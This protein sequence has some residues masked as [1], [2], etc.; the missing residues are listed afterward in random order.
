MITIIKLL[1]KA[2]IKLAKLIIYVITTSFLI[3]W[4][5]KILGAIESKPDAEIYI[6]DMR[7]FIE[8]TITVII[9]LATWLPAVLKKYTLACVKICITFYEWSLKNKDLIIQF[10]NW[11]AIIG[12]YAVFAAYV[13]KPWI[14]DKIGYFFS[15]KI[16][17]MF[18][19]KIL[20]DFKAYF[21]LPKIEIP[22][23]LK[24]TLLVVLFFTGFYNANLLPEKVHQ[25]TEIFVTFIYLFALYHKVI[26]INIANDIKNFIINVI[27]PMWEMREVI[28]WYIIKN[29]Y[30]H[31]QAILQ[32]I[33]DII[34]KKP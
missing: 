30:E 28:F 26:F 15:E 31:I 6:E 25:I 3:W 33:Q 14:F 20:E 18:K 27:I 29:M 22:V 16:R 10:S 21:K 5:I 4:A 17:K 34:S 1:I 11:G 9:Y 24:K 13:Y 23:L 12:L 7:R 19:I 8:N 2:T 32:F